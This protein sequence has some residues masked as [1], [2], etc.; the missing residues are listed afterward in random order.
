MIK[1]SFPF[2]YFSVWF[3]P[4]KMFQKRHDLRWFQI[5]LILL[6]L[7]ALNILPV[8]FFYQKQQ[9]IPLDLYFA[10]VH[11]LL[12]DHGSHMKQA[13]QAG[14]FSDGRYRFNHEQVLQ[15]DKQGVVGVD[16]SEKQLAHTKNAVVLRQRSFIFKENGPVNRLYYGDSFR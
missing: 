4:T 7:F 9:S 2:N 16:L 14:Q 12:Q 11:R 15:E 5:V 10:H 13:S 8:P 3:S 1:E 6:F